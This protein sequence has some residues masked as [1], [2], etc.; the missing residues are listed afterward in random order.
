VHSKVVGA[1]WTKKAELAVRLG[2]YNST[3]ARFCHVR[4]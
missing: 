4:V 2:I 3:P 1:F